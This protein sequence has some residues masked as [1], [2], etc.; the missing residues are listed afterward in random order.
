VLL[1]LVQVGSYTFNRLGIGPSAALVILLASLLGSAVNV[2][3]AR[4]KNQ[5][6]QAHRTVSVFGVRYLI[7]MMTRQ[8]TVIAVNVGGALVPVVL[9]AYLIA[10]DHIGWQALAAATIRGPASSRAASR[11]ARA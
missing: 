6:V 10:H 3:V 11:T 2:P 5:V 8:N 4:L 7:P 1:V 9:S